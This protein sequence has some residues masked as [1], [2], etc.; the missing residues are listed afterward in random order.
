MF[1]LVL[2][3]IQLIIITIML[4]RIV[5]SRIIILKMY[6]VVDEVNVGVLVE[7][8]LEEVEMWAALIALQT[9]SRCVLTASS[10]VRMGMLQQSALL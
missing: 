5:I 1:R 9:T 4:V 8:T 10:V 6:V 3:I 2:Q 7:D